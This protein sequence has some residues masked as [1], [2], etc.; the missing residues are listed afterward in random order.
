M[1]GMSR[2]RSLAFVALVAVSAM[3]CTGGGG[4][5]DPM[6]TQDAPVL[7]AILATTD[8]YVGMPQRIGIG[9]VLN[10]GR[11]VSYGSADFRFSYLGTSEAPT[12]ARQGPSATGVYLPTPGTEPGGGSAAITQPSE[13]RGVYQAEDVTFDE[14]GF[15]QVDVSADVEGEGPMTATTVFPVNGEPL[16][17]APGMPA[18]ERE[19]LTRDSEDAPLA[20]IDSRAV[21]E[22]EVPDEI[23]HETTIAEAL[24][25]GRPALVVFSTPLFCQTQFCGPITDVVEGLA[26]EHGDRAEFIHVEIWREYEETS[27]VINQAAADWLLRNNDL[28]E[29]W[30]YLIDGN[31]TIVDRWAV[32]FRPEEIAAALEALPRSRA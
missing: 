21:S 15:W 14:E 9:L 29:P 26:R 5:P 20:A 25:A 1:D 6:P 12:D 7:N 18:L 32:L 22:G 3:A 11:L 30:L 16:L 8:H 4:D 17:P 28:T 2:F 27:Q 31:G 10:D 19:N 23:L 24:E 13:A